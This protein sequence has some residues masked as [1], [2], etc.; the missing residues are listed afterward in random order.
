MDRIRP[1]LLPGQPVAVLTDD[2][3]RALLTVRDGREFVDR[4]DA[5]LIRLF[6]DTGFRRGEVAA[7]CVDD[8]LEIAA[9]RLG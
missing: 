7:L 9:D 2:Q 8:R 5:A 6:V 1:S 3:L 4:R